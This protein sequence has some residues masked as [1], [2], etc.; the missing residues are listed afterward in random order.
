MGTEIFFIL[1]IILIAIP[2]L[3]YFIFSSNKTQKNKKSS[4]KKKSLF[5]K[6]KNISK[7][8]RIKRRGKCNYPKEAKKLKLEAVLYIDVHISK[9]GEII[10]FQ[11]PYEKGYGFEREAYKYIRQWTFYPAIENG[12]KIDS[13]IRV[14]IQFK[15][16][17]MV[18]E[19]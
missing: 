11:I 4:S 15:L 5:A 8:V 2:I 16:D 7:D 14:P 1:G 3:F 18:R 10:E 19:I 13:W 9:D 12:Q 17:K 6:N